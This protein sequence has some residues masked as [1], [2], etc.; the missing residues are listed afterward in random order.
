[1]NFLKEMKSIIPWILAGIIIGLGLTIFIQ[2]FLVQG[3]SMEHTFNNNDRIF[4]SK[5]SYWRNTPSRQDIVIFEYEDRHLVKRVIGV[6]N[7]RVYIDGNSVYVNG[8]ELEEP[9]AKQSNNSLYLL[10]NTLEEVT[11]PDGYVFVLGDN[12][13]FSYDS[14][15]FGFISNETIVGKA[16]YRFYPFNS[17]KRF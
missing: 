4:I 11:V 12:R 8:I 13:E 17:M 3:E 2:P 7:D 16:V 10:N 5:T 14:R 6:A 15:D 1:M 9:Y